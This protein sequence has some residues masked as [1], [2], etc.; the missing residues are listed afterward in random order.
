MGGKTHNNNKKIKT[1]SMIKNKKG[2]KSVA[3]KNRNSSGSQ[4]GP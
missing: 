1:D 2:N 4:A 3:G